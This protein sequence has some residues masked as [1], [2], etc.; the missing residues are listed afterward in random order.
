VERVN[1]QTLSQPIVKTNKLFSA[2]VELG[3][4]ALSVYGFA[5]AVYWYWVFTQSAPVE[6]M[7]SGSIILQGVPVSHIIQSLLTIA[8]GGFIHTTH[9]LWPEI[10]ELFKSLGK[11]VE[12]EAKRV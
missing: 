2:A 4:V 1:S 7:A 8:L 12:S 10:L 9:R 5:S 3:S 11:D 6:T